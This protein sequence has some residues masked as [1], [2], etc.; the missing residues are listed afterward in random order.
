MFAL[1]GFSHI[2]LGLLFPSY[3]VFYVAV[4]SPFSVSKISISVGGFLASAKFVVKLL[5]L[6]LMN[7]LQFSL[8]YGSTNPVFDRKLQQERR[9]RMNEWNEHTA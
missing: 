2:G 6:V 1:A 3:T 8:E 4:T 7:L 5:L 9:E